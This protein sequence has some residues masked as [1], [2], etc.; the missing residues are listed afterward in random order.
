MRASRWNRVRGHVPGEGVR[1][2]VRH[3]GSL[4]P[5][6]GP[7]GWAGRM[8]GTFR[9]GTWVFSERPA[10]A[11]AG[12]SVGP[13]G[14]ESRGHAHPGLAPPGTGSGPRAF[15]PRLPKDSGASVPLGLESPLSPRFPFGPAA[16]G[17][18]WLGG[19]G[20]AR[21]HW[22]PRPH[23][24]QP[25]AP[26]FPALSGPGTR[27]PRPGAGPLSPAPGSSRSWATPLPPCEGTWGWRGLGIRRRGEGAPG[28]CP[29]LQLVKKVV[30]SGDTACLQPTLDV[31]SPEDR[32]LLQGHCHAR[33]LAILRA[34][35]SG[36]EGTAHTREAIAYLSLA[37][38]AAGRSCPPA[39]GFPSCAG[40][41]GAR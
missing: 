28:D 39:L 7:R 6:A 23:G 27:R 4:S 18:P 25:S 14:S 34:R 19:G 2:W 11:A 9:S 26:R 38:F 8:P 41:V 13:S 31:F 24:E 17:P 12:L 20:A 10:G 15:A 21:G 30:Q 32:Q 1:L 16:C 33:A 3:S 37:I 40:Y 29:A 36:A 22:D 5:C 35:P